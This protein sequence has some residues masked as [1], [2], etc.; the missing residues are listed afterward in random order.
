M[1]SSDLIFIDIEEFKQRQIKI[2]TDPENFNIIREHFTKIKDVTLID[3]IKIT[4]KEDKWVL[5]RP[6]NTEK[7]IRLSVEAKNDTEAK[8]LTIEYEKLIKNLLKNA[9]NH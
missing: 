3:G 4:P 2:K 1:C 9:T 5:I 8:E 6:S 7:C